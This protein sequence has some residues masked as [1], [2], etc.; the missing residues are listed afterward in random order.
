MCK[1]M[2]CLYIMII[3]FVCSKV[4]RLSSTDMLMYQEMWIFI[5]ILH[6][7]AHCNGGL[8]T[9]LFINDIKQRTRCPTLLN[10]INR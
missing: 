1:F 9:S 4:S 8:E 5:W 7:F 6:I 10:V 2:M 3:G